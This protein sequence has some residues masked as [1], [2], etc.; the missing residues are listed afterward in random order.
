M[1]RSELHHVD[2]RVATTV[3]LAVALLAPGALFL[4][5]IVGRSLQPVEHEPS[6]TFNAI[7]NGFLALPPTIAI[8]LIIVAPLVA[9]ALAAMVV[10]RTVATDPALSQDLG[11]LAD[12][13]MPLLRRPT[14]LV[15]VA[16]LVVAAGLMGVLIVHALAG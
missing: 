14:L 16:I 7:T 4:V 6:R 10:W 5:S 13:A 2:R 9:M 1:I 3:A 11:R 15:A 8:G 12:A